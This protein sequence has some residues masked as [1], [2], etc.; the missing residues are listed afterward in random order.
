MLC[1]VPQLGC[2]VEALRRTTL[3]CNLSTFGWFR[4]AGCQDGL[5][6]AVCIQVKLQN[7][8][9]DVHERA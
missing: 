6:L 9:A 4:V 7:A 5:I 8:C 2:T 3:V 1:P